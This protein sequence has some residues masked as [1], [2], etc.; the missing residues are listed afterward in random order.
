MLEDQ[1][2]FFLQ[3]YLG[4]YVR[5]LNKEA[6]KISVWKGDVELTNMQLRPEALNALNLPVRVKAGFLGSVRLKVPWSRLGQ[7]PVLVYLDRILILAEPA[8]KVEGHSED[9]LQEA[10][11]TKVRELE[12]KLLESQQQLKSEMNASW[13]GSLINT[14]IGNLK[15]SITNI[16]IRYEDIE[17]NPG[18]PF[19][20]GLTLAKLSAV[21][22]DDSGKET[23]VTGGDL[24]RIQ[25]SVELQR[26]AVYFDS[27]S[28]PWKVDKPW[29]DL[30][31]SEWCQIFELGKEDGGDLNAFSEEHIYMLEPVTGNA[32]YTKMR[33]AESKSTQQALQKAA[34]NLDNVTLSLSKD[35]YRDIMKMV[36]N[37]SAFN[38]RLKYAHY[39]PPALV[40]S[41]PK[42]WWKYAY[43]VVTDE[44]KKASGKLSWE[45]VL[46][47]AKLRKKY[48]SLYASLLK[49]DLSRLIVDDNE[50]IKN[51]D[52]QLD[53]EVILQ[54][55]M[56]AHKLVEQSARSDLYPK[57]NPKR[58]W[59][60][61]GWTGSAKEETEFKGFAEEDWERLNKVIGYKENS[62]EYVLSFQDKNLIQF[63][64]EVRMKHNASKLIIEGVECLADLSCEEFLCNL[65][66]YTEAKTFDLKLGSYRL[67]SPYG[68]LAESATAADSFVGVF[69]YKPLDSQVD[70]SFVAKASP[71]YV[72]YLKE[73][74]DQIVAFFKST[75][76]IS[77]SLALGTVAAMQMTIDEVRRTAQQQVTRALKDQPR[78]SL[79]LDIAAP[80]I[81]IPTKFCPDGF[82]ETKLLLDLGTFLLRTQ[83]FCD[84][85]SSEEEDIY[86]QFNM[87]L[88]DV[89]AFLVDGNYRWSEAS[90]E[91]GSKEPASSNFLPVIDKCGIV[92]KL[93]QNQS[94]VPFYPSTRLAIRLPSLGFHFSPARYH[95]LMQVA[96][97]FEDKDTMNPDVVHPWNLADFE[98]WLSLLTWK[99]VGNREA[100]WQHRYFC[101]VGP[102]LYILESPTS[103]TYKQCLSLRGK[104]VHQVPTELTGGLQ[105]ILALYDSGQSNPKVLEDVNAVILLCDNDELRK[106]WHNRLQ[107]AIYRASGSAAISTLSETSSPSSIEK[108]SSPKGSRILDFVNTEK[109]FVAGVLDELKICFSCCYQANQVFK[110]MLLCKESNLFEF[111]ALGGQVELS[112]KESN[113]F[114]GTILRSLEIE[115]QYCCTGMTMP[116]YLARSFIDSTEDTSTQSL[117]SS[118]TSSHKIISDTPIKKNDSVENFFEASDHLDDFI[119]NSVQRQSS[120]SEYF[121]A[122]ASLPSPMLSLMPPSFSRIP[123]LLPDTEL[124]TGS[125]NLEK[126]DT[127]GSFVKAQLVIYNQNSPQYRNLDNRVIVTLATLTFFCHRPTILAI[128]EFANA[129]NFVNDNDGDKDMDKPSTSVTEDA[130]EP[131]SAVVQEAAIRGLFGRG[132]SRV[133][134]HLT[135]NMAKAQI[136]L[137]NENGN[138]LATLSQNNLLTE[139]KVFPSSFNIKAALGNLKISDDSLPSSHSYFWICDMRNPGGSSFVEIDFSS[140]NIDDED[141]CGFDYSLVGQLS[142]VRIVYLNR[143]VQDIISYF[144]GLVPRSAETVVKLKDHVTDSEKWVSKTD[145]E[146]SPALKLDLSL[147]RPVI[148]M[149]R[150]TD[151]LDYLELDVLFITIQNTFQW[152][153]G[154]RNEMSAIHQEILTIKVKDINLTVGIDMVSGESIIQDVKGFSLVVHRSLRD[155]LHQVPTVEAAIEIE[156][157]KATLSN[158]EY[159]IITECAASNFSETQHPVPPLDKGPTSSNDAITY[160]SPVS[161]E[162]SKSEST[163]SEAWITMRFS[164]IIHLVEL[165]LH[166]GLTRDSS[167]ASVQATGAWLLYK[168]NARGEGFLFATLKGFSVFDNREGTKEELRL[169]IGKSA[170]IRD[171]SNFGDAYFAPLNNLSEMGVQKKIDPEPIPSMLILDATF[172]KSSTNVSLCVQRP[173]FLVA[174]DFLL[175]VVEFFVPSVRSMLSNEEEKESLLILSEVVFDDQIYTQTSSTAFLSPRKPLIVDDERFDQFIYDGEGGKLYLQDR[176]GKILSGPCPETFIYVGNGK[177]LQFRNVTIM[178]GEYL[179]SC[180]SLGTNSSYSA[181]EDDHVYLERENK[182]ALSNS[183]EEKVVG[184]VARKSDADE[185]TEFVMELQAIGPELTF[186]STSKFVGEPLELST[187]VMHAHLDLLCRIV[188]KGD[189][190]EMCGN[191]LGLDVDSNSIR[192]LEPFDTTVKYSNISG[193][194]NIHVVVSEIYMNFSFSILR[195]LLA[196]EEDIMAFLRMSSKKVSVVCSQFDKVGTMRSHGNGHTYAFWRPR[197]PSGYAILGDCLTP[198]N[199][200]PSKGVLAVNTSLVRVKRPVAYKLIWQAGTLRADKCQQDWLTALSY[201]DNGEEYSGCSIWLPIAPKGYVP[202]GCVVSA[203]SVE[204]SLSSASCIMAPM[205]SL[206]SLRDCIALRLSESSLADVAFWRVDNSFGSFLPG[207]SN[208]L[209]LIG[210]PYDLR[211]MIFGNPESS[212]KISRSSTIQENP[213]SVDRNPQLERSALRTSGWFFEAIASFKLIWWNHGM[214]SQKK[215]S[216]WRPMVPRGLIYLGDLAIDGYEPPNSALVLRDTGDETL[217]RAPQGFQLVG[218]IKKQRGIEGISFWYPQAPPGFV[219]LGCIASKGSPKVEDFSSLRCIRSDMVT[220]DQFSE[221]S[222]W[223]TSDSR[224]S[225]D[226][227]LWSLGN[228]L[229]TFLV[230]SG[231]RKPPKR[232]ALRIAGQSTSTG[233]DST[234]IDAEIKTFSAVAFDDYGGLMVPLFGTSFNNISFSLHGRPDYLNATAS[235]SL[236]ARSFNDRYDSW[237]PLIEPTDGFLRYQYDMNT[238]GALSQLRMTSTHDLNLNI[239]AANV[240]M[241]FQAY[242]SWNNLSHIDESY[243][244]KEAVSPPH[245]EKAILDVH[246][247][248][249]YYIIPLNKLGQDI[250]IRAI[251]FNRVPNIIQMPSGD[252]KPIKVPVSKNLLDSHVKLKAGRVFRSMVTVIIADAELRISGGLATSQYVTTVRLFSQHPAESPLQQQSAR[253]CAATSDCFLHGSAVVNWG[254]MF[255]FKV[256]SVDDFILEFIVIDVGRGEPIGICSA[257]LKQVACE[258]PPTSDSYDANFQMTWRELASAKSM[259]RENDDTVRSLGRIRCGVLLSVRPENET[260]RE[261]HTTGRRTGYIQISPAREGPW[262]TV[263]LNYAAPAACWRLGNDVIASEVI[264]KD[265][266]RYVNIRSL[267]SVTN[268]TDFAIDVRLQGRSSSEHPRSDDGSQNLDLECPDMRF[269]MDELFEQEIFDPSGGW[270]RCPSFISGD[271]SKKFHTD[272]EHQG[273]SS[274]K[275]PEGWEWTDDWHVDKASVG[276]ADGWVYASDTEHLK[277]P[278]SSNQSNSVNYARQRRWIRHRKYIAHEKKSQISVGVLS[279]GDTAP[280]P[281]SALTHPVVSYLLQLRPQNP[282]DNKEYTWSTVRDIENQT[283]ISSR[284]EELSGICVSELS[285]SEELLFCSQLDGS[286]SDVSRGLWFCASIRAKEIG[287]DIHSDPIHDWNIVIKSP[288]SLIYYLP[289]SSQYAISVS[290]SKGEYIPCSQGSLCPGRTV[291]IY[292]ADLRDP[293]YLSLVPQGWGLIHEPVVISDPSGVPAKFLNLRNSISGRIVQVILEQNYDKDRLVARTIRICVPFW[294][295][296]SRCPPLI[297]RVVDMSGKREGRHSRISIHSDIRSE[298]ILWQ[299]TQEEMVGGY[300]IASGLNFKTLGISASI[301]KHGKECFGPVRELAPLGDMDGSIDLSAYD[302]DGSCMRVLVSSKPSPYQAVPTKVISIRPFMTF[303]NRVGQDVFIKINAGDH[304]KTLCAFDWRVSFLYSEAGGSDQLQVRLADTEWCLPVEIVKED[305]I[306]I[307]LRKQHG[308]RQFLKAEIRGYEEGSRFLIVFRLGS[309]DG[310]IRIENRMNHMIIHAR[311]SGLDENAWIHLRPLSTTKF[312]W[313]DPYGRRLLD[314]AIQSGDETYIHCVSLEKPM[315]SCAELRARG[316]RLHIMDYGDIKIVQFADDRIISQMGQ[317]EQSDS[318]LIYHSVSSSSQNEMQSNTAPL[319]LIVEIGV[320]GLSLVDHRP[321]ELL[322][323]Y[324]ER[325]FISYSTGYDS[326]KTSRFKLIIGHLQLDNQLPLTLMPVL[327]APEDMADINHPVFKAT[328]TISNDTVDGTQVYPYVYIRVTEKCWR[329]NIHEPIIW[330]L[331]DLYN[332]LRIDSIPSSSSVTQ[333]DPEVRIGLIDISEVRF[334][335]SLGTAPAERPRGVLGIWSPVLSAVGNAFKIQVHLRKVM[336][337]N[338]SMRKSSIVPAIVNRIRRDLIHNPLHLIFSVDVLG[339]TKSTLASLSKGFAELSTDGQFLQLRS[340]QVWS[341]RITGVGDGILQ[342]TEAFAQGV[343]FGVSGVLTKPVENARQHGLL[344]F[345]HGL[346]RAFLGFVVQPLS[347]ALDFVSLTVD[348]ISASFVRCLEILSNK[349]ITQRIRNPRAI[350]ADGVIREY[351]RKEAVGQMVLYLAEAS[352][353]LGCTDLFKEPSKYAWS[354]YYED[355]FIVPFQR[356]VL[357]TNKRVMLLQ[358]LDVDKMDRKPC[359]IIWD[360]PWEELL[361]LELAKAGHQKPSHLIIHLKNFRRSESFVRLIRCNVD[362]DEEHDPQAVII[363]SSIQKIW[364]AN[365]A[366]MKIISLKVPS[367][368]RHVQFA[369]DEMD[370]RESHS[371]PRSMIKERRS[372][373]S[374]DRRFVKHIVNF[375]KIWS[376]EQESRRR[377]TLFAKQVADDGTICSFWRSLCPDGYISI[378]DV[379]HIGHHPPHVAAIYRNSDGNFALPIGYDL[380]WRNCSDDYSSPVSVWLPRPPDG[381]VALGCVALADYEEPPLD[382]VYCAS[383]RIVEETSFEE[384]IVWTAPDSY[385]WACYLYQ[386]QSEALQFVALRKRKEESDWRP[387]RISDSYPPRLSEGP[388]DGS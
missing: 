241:F 137:M 94:E 194:T 304:P 257:P 307:V 376:S 215:L 351:S 321:R 263:R 261:D 259:I 182:V 147:N 357:V 61:F 150:K 240:N 128:L 132:K 148:L 142:E 202:V 32:K 372:S 154:G 122:Q 311:Q 92:V 320:I 345:A 164:S 7:E 5:G 282:D 301:S 121:S 129:I 382:L 364:K 89:S 212:R 206:C 350:H 283:E 211:H 21:T 163:D 106:T 165:S 127:L 339:M 361:A 108:D 2:A 146:G 4:N 130:T 111:R 38:Q 306:T 23:F 300:S 374:A 269:E 185:S 285:E 67:S 82:H 276:T 313:E 266:N 9:A 190:L 196:V 317:H 52:H 273:P 26:L 272:I 384:Q 337:K 278:E 217:L 155:L 103:T 166:S 136:L 342:G 302:T 275:L 53:I 181:S 134:F 274:V 238:P 366:D 329:L 179:D 279:P 308:G 10:K 189:S 289:F 359:K 195:L 35:G 40:K 116:R 323:L 287:K 62:D 386:V 47:Y 191:I 135:L 247:R 27:D 383:E 78:F 176:N 88:S 388:S 310:P 37:F 223:D 51:L 11:K 169:A 54:W 243:K 201:D 22:V 373:S 183:S 99:G 299:V 175:V 160:P 381:Y 229:G 192:V 244:K 239:S 340:K 131:S 226:F 133:I 28:S 365:Q 338:R 100:V 75:S 90:A 334:K 290:H 118:T 328:I 220:G 16:H 153:G 45:Q 59:W 380:V 225:E 168:S 167:L 234:V 56:L 31:P 177:Q 180:I 205:V 71:C 230:R 93:Q 125:L 254:E 268:N 262:T 319:E 348:G 193:K 97:I 325:V 277:W 233:S 105:N 252:D 218:R 138:S 294:I 296:S 120:L 60:S 203:G 144:M 231:F 112:M 115:D 303:T 314:V 347:G 344:G 224:V 255:F 250:Y 318:N 267:V 156:V 309:A 249:N 86:L 332:N 87:V 143:F 63:S 70:W 253:T 327:L 232:F 362:E 360:V 385:P 83:D 69:S 162:T 109:L 17:S 322:Y 324:L 353:H 77:Q 64:L 6:L 15:L 245:S 330:A 159:Q 293:L 377:C 209:S 295:S 369:W 216:V 260:N 65:N 161:S 265:G 197:A 58:S 68:L 114:I 258:L 208:D 34:V 246:H 292:N 149:P 356:I 188:L 43:K 3:K 12:M 20:A 98:G 1:V 42:S 8:T 236:A 355:H 248:K 363:C 199:E 141:Y 316:I 113:I 74:I 187:K 315:D 174:L 24:D 173:K 151:S 104:Q 126:N 117:F 81:T 19:A 39:R 305:T 228:D 198:L 30:L 85:N 335:I 343:A 297:Y 48:I 124:E 214:N 368:Q 352:T 66:T 13:L 387:V 284:H 270:V 256:D 72:T 219:A 291:K 341:R 264:V 237:E 288:L 346:G 33:L 221:E 44:M 331:V 281:L 312:A 235:F 271:Q 178:S 14:I 46:R 76:D 102:Y 73:S 336:H 18:H 354:D 298:K 222:I 251:E 119:D 367:S 50:E 57:Q 333:V 370:G 378:G 326:G 139:I 79:D 101:L 213:R 184:D 171:T 157:L 349:S 375:Q 110:K 36:D 227:S 170:T 204:P 80:K 186:Y 91:V 25:K 55:R 152:I 95:R 286:S 140:F 172:R 280:L 145:I 96:K 107:G 207:D 158:R 84:S 358:C 29:E 379:A 210:K 123:G 41:D 200:P 242:S 49:S 371:L